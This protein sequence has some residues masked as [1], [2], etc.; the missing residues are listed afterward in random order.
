MQK[1]ILAGAVAAAFLSGCA[2]GPSQQLSDCL[3]PNRR[4]AVEVV[5]TV[6]APKPKPKPEAQPEAKPE[7]KPEAA[8][9][10][11]PE[12]KPKKPARVPLQLN[13]LAQGNSAFDVGSAVLKDGGK[14]DLDKLAGTVAKRQMAV[15]AIVI[16]GHTDRFEAESAGANLAEER[17]KSVMNYLVSKGMDQKL[18]FWEGKGAKEPV[19]VTKFCE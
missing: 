14:E 5:G 17:A 19:P 2:T 16:A 10:A 11:K 12:A 13:A 4:V 15:G 8:P 6:P 18:M 3:Q 7:A 9:E 1:I